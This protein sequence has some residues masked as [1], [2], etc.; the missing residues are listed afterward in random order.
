MGPPSILKPSVSSHLVTYVQQRVLHSIGRWTAASSTRDAHHCNSVWRTG[1][2]IA[3]MLIGRCILLGCM[4]A[5]PYTLLTSSL[6]YSF[7]RWH[8]QHW[9][10]QYAFS[11]VNVHYQYSLC[12][13]HGALSI[14][15]VSQHVL[16]NC[17]ERIASSQRYVFLNGCRSAFKA[18][19]DPKMIIGGYPPGT[20]D[21]IQN[22]TALLI[23]FPVN[24]NA[25]R[26]QEIIYWEEAFVETV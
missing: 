7:C 22:A 12:P 18:P 17:S 1:P 24:N 19:I 15:S 6:S 23:T 2:Q 9:S 26:M 4:L 20:T 8:C 16:G 25:T 13:M 10:L 3:G 5:W 11:F 21:F 14:G